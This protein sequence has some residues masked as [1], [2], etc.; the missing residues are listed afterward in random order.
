MKI[1]TWNVNSIKARL[2]NVLEFLSEYKPDVV[3]L[4]ELKCIEEAFPYMEIEELGYNCAVYGQ[5]TYNGVAI[6][7]KYP[8]EDIRKGLPEF[9]EEQDARYIEALVN[10]NGDVFRVASVYVPNG[11]D[12]ASHKF[13]YKLDFFSKLYNH[14]NNIKNL[15]EKIVIGGDF[16]VAHK[17][18]DVFDP[19]SLRGSICFH[20][21]EQTAF[22]KIL[23]NKYIDM[24][25]AYHPERQAFSWWDYRGNAW[26]FNKGMRID[27]LLCN[28]LAADSSMNCEI[29]SEPRGKEKASDHTP[30]LAEFRIK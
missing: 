2:P 5:K 9:P 1:I 7:S 19:K 30:V 15:E 16:N 4:Q 8:L 11:M 22:T 26:G 21:D 18:I 24:F 25:R 23:N 13:Q 28:P 17:D 6:L 27:Y 3:L 12:T 20:P 10:A 14:L 29:I